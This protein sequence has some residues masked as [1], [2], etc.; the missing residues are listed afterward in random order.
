MRLLINQVA[1][2]FNNDHYLLAENLYF[3]IFI[4]HSF[5]HNSLKHEKEESNN[6][7][8][9]Q[10]ALLWNCQVSL[11]NSF[12]LDS[13]FFE[14]VI[15]M[16]TSPDIFDAKLSGDFHSFK[17]IFNEEMSRDTKIKTH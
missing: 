4:K 17:N 3:L 16:L 2:A 6:Q 15:K 13:G 5:K 12:F 8:V 1:I 7:A 10:P 11:H 9:L 14:L